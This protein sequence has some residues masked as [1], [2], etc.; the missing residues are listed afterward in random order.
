M[1]P[2]Y[3]ALSGVVADRG[4][5]AAA[6]RHNGGKGMFVKFAA[7]AATIAFGFAGTA[8][9]AS[10]IFTLSSSTFTDGKLMPKK[11]ANTKTNGN[12]NPN[13]VGDNV[14]P[15]FSWSDVPEGTKSF[16]FLMI[17]PEGR[18]GAGVNH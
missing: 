13:C 2:D 4:G 8:A 18:G 17:D 1:A 10:G 5:A 11:V 12:N 16:V 15:Q 3:P 9:E 14:S 6:I 7:V